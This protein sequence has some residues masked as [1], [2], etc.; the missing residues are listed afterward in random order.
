MSSFID[1]NSKSPYGLTVS[2]GDSPVFAGQVNYIDLEES[3]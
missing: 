3:K 2:S 1:L